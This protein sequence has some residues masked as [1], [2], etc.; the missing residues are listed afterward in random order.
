MA[1]RYASYHFQNMSVPTPLRYEIHTEKNMF[2]WKQKAYPIWKLERSDNDPVWWKHSTRFKILEKI[3]C[4]LPCFLPLFWGART[5]NIIL[6]WPISISLSK[7][8]FAIASFSLLTTLVIF[9]WDFAC[10]F[11]S[12][13]SITAGSTISFIILLEDF[14]FKQDRGTLFGD[15]FLVCSFFLI[16]FSSS[17]CFKKTPVLLFDIIV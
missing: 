13:W 10:M 16:L 7:S 6:I 3:L 2:Q 12:T 8:F 9:F 11:L 15:F 17:F 5:D 4:F 1:I 14:H